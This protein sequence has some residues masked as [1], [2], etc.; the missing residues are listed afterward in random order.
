MVLVEVYKLILPYPSLYFNMISIADEQFQQKQGHHNIWKLGITCFS[1][2]KALASLAS[3]SLTTQ[4]SHAE[5]YSFK[6]TEP[7]HQLELSVEHY[8]FLNSDLV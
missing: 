6:H 2:Y 8:C 7:T 1:W 5:N 3:Q 4:N